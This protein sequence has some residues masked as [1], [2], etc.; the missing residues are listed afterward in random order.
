MKCR[1]LSTPGR[2]LLALVFVLSALPAT[3]ADAATRVDIYGGG[4]NLVKLAM[5]TPLRG[6]GNPA[7]GLGAE[8]NKAIAGQA[9]ATGAVI[10]S[11][12]TINAPPVSAADP[13]DVW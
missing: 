11:D 4:Q 9:Q 8:L 12:G 5:A 3:P 2:V 1:I 6:G 13:G 10:D 7:T